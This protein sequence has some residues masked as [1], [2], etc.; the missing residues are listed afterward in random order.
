MSYGSGT[1]GFQPRSRRF[2]ARPS[3]SWPAPGA[4]RLR[5]G[6]PGLAAFGG[7]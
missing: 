4:R 6:A 3:P 1:L 5:L 7:S 2:A